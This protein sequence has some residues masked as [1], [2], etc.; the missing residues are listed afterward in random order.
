M[1]GL[2][3]AGLWRLSTFIVP[4]GGLTG[5][6]CRVEGREGHHGA[7]VARVRAGDTVRLIDGDG[8]EALARVD[9]VGGGALECTVTDR[10][11]HDS[12]GAVSL[13]VAQALLK[14]RAFDEVVRRLSEL[15]AAGIVPLVTERAIG[16]VPPD[17]LESR[18]E[19][20]RS[21]A[22]AAVKQS[23]GVFLPEL[24]EPLE[25][26]GLVR[27]SDEFDLVL[28]AWE[29]ETG[30]TLAEALSG[31]TPSGSATSGGAADSLPAAP[32]ILLVVGPEGG[33]SESEVALLA[34]AGAVSVS[35]GRRV[36]KAD[37]AAAAIAAMIGYELGGLLP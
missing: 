24:V 17:A 30:R 22:A 1:A 18:L 9:A 21:V 14:G 5:G 2:S 26:A 25:V 11:R 6:T 15:G 34:E 23:R 19:R 16:R 10:R 4:P 35:V 20:W 12:A 13:T 32:R 8:T 37:W 7:D 29:D 33:L 31:V 3:D 36:L 28:V 27:K